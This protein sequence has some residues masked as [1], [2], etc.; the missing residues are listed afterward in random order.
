[1]SQRIILP[2]KLELKT[3]LLLV[4]S[5][6]KQQALFLPLK[7]LHTEFKIKLYVW[8]SFFC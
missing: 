6:K 1:M 3:I 5:L 2:Q 8:K 7:H 4:I